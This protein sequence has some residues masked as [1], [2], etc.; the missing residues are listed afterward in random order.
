M[1][2]KKTNIFALRKHDN[3]LPNCSTLRLR[4][5]LQ[6]TK[7]HAQYLKLCHTHKNSRSNH[8]NQSENEMPNEKTTIKGTTNQ[9]AY[10]MANGKILAL[11]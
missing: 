3:K 2:T 1:L 11:R 4:S 5:Q 7:G 10:K 9:S 6:R 8:K